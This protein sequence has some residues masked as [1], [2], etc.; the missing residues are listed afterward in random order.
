MRFLFDTNVVSELRHPRGDAEVKRRVAQLDP[1]AVY[2]SA[3]VVG[4]IVKGVLRLPR[5]KKRTGLLAWLC[6]LEVE[7]ADRIPPFDLETARIW[8]RLATEAERA[9]ES[10]G[11]VD[12]QIAASALQ[13]GFVLVTRNTKAFERTGARLWNV[14]KNEAPE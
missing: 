7:Y 14:W 9:G 12:G 4:E 11:V 10:L 13:H 1:D 6:Q 3:M 5:G 8:G 2:L